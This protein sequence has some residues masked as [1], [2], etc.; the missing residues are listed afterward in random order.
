MVRF[1]FKPKRCNAQNVQELVAFINEQNLNQ[2]QELRM[3]FAQ[4]NREL[5]DLKKE[6]KT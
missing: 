5:E 1:P 3:A 6:R 4:V 2:T